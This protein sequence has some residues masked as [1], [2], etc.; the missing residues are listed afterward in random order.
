M[1][2]Y[3]FNSCHGGFA[4]SDKFWEE[5]ERRTGKTETDVKDYS[6]EF[7]RDPVVISIIG[8]LGT[9]VST[10][11]S[12]ELAFREFPDDLIEFAM[13]SEY[14]GMESVRLSKDRLM[15]SFIHLDLGTERGVTQA[16]ELQKL[17]KRVDAHPR[18]G[19]SSHT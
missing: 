16:Q 3:V 19:D 7:R 2:K 18:F 8:D 5:Y 17:A 15:K 4:L 14:D 12:S 1:G 6:P 11:E 9:G 10:G 13:H